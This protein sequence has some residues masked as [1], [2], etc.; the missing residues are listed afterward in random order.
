MVRPIA[1][2]RPNARMNAKAMGNQHT[3][4][5]SDQG[6]P[7][8]EGPMARAVRQHDWAATSVGPPSSWPGSARSAVEMALSSGAPMCVWLIVGGD[9]PPGPDPVPIWNDAFAA[10]A[11]P[12]GPP[13]GP[14]LGGEPGAEARRWYP[15]PGTVAR[16]GGGESAIVRGVGSGVAGHHGPVRGGDGRLTA[17]LTVLAP[18]NPPGPGGNA[19][20]ALPVA[21]FQHRV[22]NLVSLIRSIARR[23]AERATDVDAYLVHFDGRLDA[24]ART[25]AMLGGHPEGLMLEDVVGEELLRQG[26]REGEGVSVEG[27]PVRLAPKAAEVL[28]LALHEL[29]TNAVKFGALAVP[30]GRVD[31]LWSLP[32]ERE[33]LRIEWRESGEVDG[34]VDGEPD[35]RGFGMEVLTQMLAYELDARVEL[36][37]RPTGLACTIELPVGPRSAP[38]VLPSEREPRR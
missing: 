10:A 30:D 37:F 27:P 4:T 22:R 1:P 24:F 38:L 36:S 18:A 32:P 20:Q 11:G 12:L 23:S 5:P 34:E 8:A 6:W 14:P 28:G 33:T 16:V 9:G 25:Q 35:Y 26:A 29:A 2:T 21:E 13:L 15:D 7:R 17:I 31:L 19:T 3:A